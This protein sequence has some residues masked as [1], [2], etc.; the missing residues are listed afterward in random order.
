MIL[1]ESLISPTIIIIDSVPLS[2]KDQ[3][4]EAVEVITILQANAAITNTDVKSPIP[5]TKSASPIYQL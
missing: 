4:N 5:P 2:T 1:A 3:N